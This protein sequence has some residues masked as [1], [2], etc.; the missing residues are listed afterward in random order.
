MLSRP[1]STIEEWNGLKS[2]P[3]MKWLLALTFLTT[4]VTLVIPKQSSERW[5][6]HQ[7]TFNH[8]VKSQRKSRTFRS[9]TKNH[10]L[11]YKLPKSSSHILPKCFQ[12]GSQ[13]STIKTN[14]RVEYFTLLE[15]CSQSSKISSMMCPLARMPTPYMKLFQLRHLLTS[16][17]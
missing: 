12:D 6:I 15:K 2:A 11:S 4:F 14:S 7:H 5:L 8:S 9:L 3:V 17:R 16:T 10:W 1:L 13:A